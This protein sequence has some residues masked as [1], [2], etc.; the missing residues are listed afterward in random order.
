MQSSCK[1]RWQLDLTAPHSHSSIEIYLPISTTE[2]ILCALSTEYYQP[3]PLLLTET[4]DRATVRLDG[5]TGLHNSLPPVLCV[6][7]CLSLG[8]RPPARYMFIAHHLN[9]LPIDA[10]TGPGIC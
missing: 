6:V 7:V 10:C 9:T 8:P 4:L 2:R 5:W 1:C 3:L